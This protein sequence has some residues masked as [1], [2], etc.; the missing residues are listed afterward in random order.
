[1]GLRLNQYMHL[2]LQ[3]S[4]SINL[5]SNSEFRH[6]LQVVVPIDLHDINIIIKKLL[7]I[8]ICHQ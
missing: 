1:M 6:L 3:A 8:I 4:Y 7:N 2:E 5:C